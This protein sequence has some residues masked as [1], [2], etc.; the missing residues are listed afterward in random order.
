MPLDYED[1][2]SFVSG[3]LAG[4][5]QVFVMQPFEIIKLRQVNE[6]QG[7]VKYKGFSRAFK[8]IL[9]EE[10]FLGFYKGKSDLTQEPKLHLLATDSNALFSLDLI[11]TSEDFLLN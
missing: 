11:D 3:A 6:Q 1:V 10:G 4:F 7:S 5:A 9:T 8:T 2:I